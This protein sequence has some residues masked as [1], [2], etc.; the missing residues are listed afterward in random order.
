MTL[1]NIL[2]TLKGI[3]DLSKEDGVMVEALFD[4]V[5]S[6]SERHGHL[7]TTIRHAKSSDGSRKHATFINY[8]YFQIMPDSSRTK[9]SRMRSSGRKFGNH[10]KTV[11]QTYYRVD[12]AYKRDLQQ[13]YRRLARKD[14]GNK[15]AQSSLLFVPQLWAIHVGEGRSMATRVCL[16]G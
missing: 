3:D 16:L 10:C 5:R 13:V 14:K 1:E 8:P 11:L 12:S 6:D 7:E 15:D 9:L 2:D 4:S